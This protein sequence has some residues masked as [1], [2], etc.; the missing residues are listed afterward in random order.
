MPGPLAHVGAVAMCPHGGMVMQIPS[1]PR[2]F[3]SGM[4]AATMADQY[5]VVGCVFNVSGVPHPCVRVQWVVPA[6]R[7]TSSVM[8]V[9]PQTAVGLCLAADQAPQGPVVIAS[10]QPRVMGT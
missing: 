3:L 5:V 4:P 2:V 10:T 6:V 1:A 7:V 8:P 9:I